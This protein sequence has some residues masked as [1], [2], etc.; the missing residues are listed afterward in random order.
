MSTLATLVVKLRA[1]IGDF[2]KGLDDAQRQAA[3]FG[4]QMTTAGRNMT[5]GISLPIVAAG[6]TFFK[7]ASD[8]ATTQERFG[9]AFGGMAGDATAFSEK[10]GRDLGL[11]AENIRQLMV[12]PEQA[13]RSVGLSASTS[14]RMTEG[15]TKLA[16]DL[17]VTTAAG[18]PVTEIM[19]QLV[20]GTGGATKGLKE[21]SIYVDAA[22]VKQYALT[23][24]L[25][26]LHQTMS[27]GTKMWATYGLIMEQTKALQG[28]F[29]A[30]LALPGVMLRQLKD[31]A[32]DV[33]RSVGTSLMGAFKA[34]IEEAKKLA[35]G[36]K[37]VADGW[38]S[39]PEGLRNVIVYLGL[40]LAAVGP[41]TWGLGLL[42]RGITALSTV[43]GVLAV[44]LRLLFTTPWGLAILAVVSLGVAIYELVTHWDGLVAA[45]KLA[46]ANIVGDL[47]LLAR[48][49]GLTGLADSLRATEQTIRASL[50]RTELEIS[51]SW[52][53][54]ARARVV[55]L[56]VMA[57]PGAPAAAAAGAGTGGGTG[58]PNLSP[59]VDASIL[60]LRT[61]IVTFGM[62]AD[63]AALYKIQ[64]EGAS[65]AQL[66]L[67]AGLLAA[68]TQAENYRAG[69]AGLAQGEAARQDSLLGTI[70]GM[71]TEI[72]T[73]GMTADAAERYR[74][75]L[76]GA[77][78]FE[79]SA[80]K[81][82]QEH[83]AELAQNQQ[84]NLM[85]A[86][87]DNTRRLNLAQTIEAM[88]IEA[89]TFGMTAQAAELY[90]LKLAGADAEQLKV[91]AHLQAMTV[92]QQRTAAESQSLSSAVASAVSG[93]AAALSKALVT[94]ANVF[95]A[96]GD[97]ILQGLGN[98]ATQVG[99]TLISMGTMIQ[100]SI[101]NPL[102]MIA[103]G[104]ALVALGSALGAIAT[105]AYG[106]GSAGGGGSPSFSSA[107]AP[108]GD[109]NVSGQGGPITIE[110]GAGG[111][112]L[113]PHNPRQMSDFAH[114][115]QAVRDRNVG[116]VILSSKTS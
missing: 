115:L 30:N 47:S 71:Q 40:A 57:P 108:V 31:A 74:L 69:I 75:A 33:A 28:A 37:G 8:A 103:A 54:S 106:G 15:L 98:V 114:M 32:E 116:K 43:L 111:Y 62:T 82:L 88:K 84:W 91:A 13:F 35:A 5:E 65:R 23:H 41:L 109:S 90:R 70:R 11:S 100:M 85:L 18:R 113:D 99:E 19:D 53:R 80:I 76:A 96:L 79:L 59:A 22:S 110:I 55:P 94:G 2:V 67:A 44:A 50:N 17:S 7:F 1:E 93:M 63:A 6:V 104:I 73:F 48:A 21:L 102:A 46:V 78:D 64:L 20:R 61:Q 58:T 112:H 83:R 89:A 101:T 12:V 45:V 92:A 29:A 52:A 9:L 51:A 34:I 3:Q 66:L 68:H 38:A 25:V 72:A 105:N 36:I 95:Q 4:R 24:G 42:I 26:G 86:A 56:A 27:E 87:S 10:L 77:D 81:L 14:L 97:A 16:Q 60:A 39:L 49:F 107:S